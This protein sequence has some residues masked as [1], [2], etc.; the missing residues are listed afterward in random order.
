MIYK[1]KNKDKL[2]KSI[3][4]IKDTKNHKNKSF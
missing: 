2:T 3:Q 4:M 1:C